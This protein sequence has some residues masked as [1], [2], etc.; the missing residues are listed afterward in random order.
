VV[1]AAPEEDES[2]KLTHDRISSPIGTLYV[3]VG[4]AGVCAVAFESERRALDALLR[5]RFG[6]VALAPGEN[7]CPWSAGLRAY[8]GG[9]LA[10]LDA[11]PVDT[12]GTAFQQQVWRALRRV[13]AGATC[14]YAD[15]AARIG[16]PTAVRAVGRANGAN[17]VPIIVP[18]HRV[19]GSDGSL[20]GYG[21]GLERKRWLLAHERARVAADGPSLFDP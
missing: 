15:L 7:T 2:M 21:G 8:L 19:I 20:I 9:D 17:P 12:G 14:S 11:I 1:H 18:C 4:A 3:V 6:S 5:S 13:P 10:A 16:R